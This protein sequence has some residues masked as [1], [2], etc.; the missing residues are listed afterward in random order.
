ML[1]LVRQF[2]LLFLFSFTLTQILLLLYFYSSAVFISNPSW[3]IMLNTSFFN[4]I[5]CPWSRILSLKY[6]MEQSVCKLALP[7][8]LAV[9][10]RS[11]TS[12]K[13]PNLS[14]L[15]FTYFTETLGDKYSLYKAPKPELTIPGSIIRNFSS[16]FPNN[17]KIIF[18]FL[19]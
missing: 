5:Q 12:G 19:I 6:K 7:L 4:E 16:G 15:S 13:L 9:T 11:H 1:C 10:N 17:H 14:R 8:I 18:A 3:L 2:I